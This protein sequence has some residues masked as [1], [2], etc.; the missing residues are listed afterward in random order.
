MVLFGKMQ[1]INFDP[2]GD[3]EYAGGN[4]RGLEHTAKERFRPGMYSCIERLIKHIA[5]RI[6]LFRVNGGVGARRVW[7]KVALLIEDRGR[8]AP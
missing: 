4:S 2:L 6:I 7:W 3:I 1:I 8:T 5:I